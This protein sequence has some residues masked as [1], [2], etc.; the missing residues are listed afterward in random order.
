MFCKVSVRSHDTYRFVP[1]ADRLPMSL[2][3]FDQTRAP[4]DA[5]TPEFAIEMSCL[6]D[7]LNA[8]HDT[9]A[10]APLVL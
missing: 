5:R 4:K 7:R 9:G 2:C 3:R 10:G 1:G 8:K 6:Q